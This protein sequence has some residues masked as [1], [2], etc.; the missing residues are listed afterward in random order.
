MDESPLDKGPHPQFSPIL[1]G[2]GGGW[3]GGQPCVNW[4]MQAPWESVHS[5]QNCQ[6]EV[7]VLKT[8]SY[9]AEFAINYLKC[10]KG[11]DPRRIAEP[12]CVT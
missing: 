5:F 3:G 4:V 2:G 1:G 6:L 9:D 8:A 11:K 12:K 10:W 7:T